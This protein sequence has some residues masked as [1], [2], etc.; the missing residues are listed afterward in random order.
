MTS[1]L[2]FKTHFFCSS[3]NLAALFFL[4]SVVVCRTFC[5]AALAAFW[6]TGTGTFTLRRH[7]HKQQRKDSHILDSCGPEIILISRQSARKSLVVYLA[8]HCHH[9]LPDYGYLPRYRLPFC[10]TKLYCLATDTCLCTTCPIMLHENGTA[11]NQTR[12]ILIA[13]VTA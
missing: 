1:T 10:S 9:F 12:N 2:N 11:G 7:L 5:I 3:P 4:L 13:S 6:W 8:V